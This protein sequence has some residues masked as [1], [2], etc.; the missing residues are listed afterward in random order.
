METVL[1]NALMIGVDYDTFWRL[2]PKSLSPFIKAFTLKYEYDDRKNWE[3]GLYI[4]MAVASSFSK[5]AKYPSK[6]FS[7][8]NMPP[9]KAQESIKRKFM[10]K[11]N[12]LNSRFRE[13]E[14]IG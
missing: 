5:D 12:E 9:E 4:K 6:P 10:H 14:K 13:E 3:L 11:M 7:E 8:S 2:N 1:P